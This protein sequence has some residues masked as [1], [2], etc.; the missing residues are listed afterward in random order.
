M[1]KSVKS[2][3]AG[4]DYRLDSTTPLNYLIQEWGDAGFGPLIA[5]AIRHRQ[6]QERTSEDEFIQ[7]VREMRRQSPEGGK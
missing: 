3:P 7:R 1:A 4:Y 6:A 2:G 5:E